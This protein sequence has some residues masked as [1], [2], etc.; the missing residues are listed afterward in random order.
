SY[1]P[2]LRNPHLYTSM[3]PFTPEAEL[4]L[5]NILTTASTDLLLASSCYLAEVTGNAVLLLIANENPG[6]WIPEIVHPAKAELKSLAMLKERIIE[7]PQSLTM[8]SKN[9]VLKYIEYSEK[10]ATL[11]HNYSR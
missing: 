7:S 3:P 2:F 11:A 9:S 1:A 8:Q 10:A 4:R 5:Q 6:K